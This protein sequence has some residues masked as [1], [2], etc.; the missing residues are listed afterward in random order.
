MS[1]NV[2]LS[3]K[4]SW[5]PEAL[6]KYSSHIK[7]SPF[8]HESNGMMYNELPRNTIS[9]RIENVP[10]VDHTHSA[11]NVILIILMTDLDQYFCLDIQL[12]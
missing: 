6:A 8:Y 12:Q 9:R 4:H 1:C 10:W 5:D 3:L 2:F 11:K 7:L